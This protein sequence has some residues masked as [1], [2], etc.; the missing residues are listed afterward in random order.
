MCVE[1]AWVV[2]VT[3]LNLLLVTRYD[4]IISAFD[5]KQVPISSMNGRL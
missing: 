2:E 4:D 1:G 5:T 3:T